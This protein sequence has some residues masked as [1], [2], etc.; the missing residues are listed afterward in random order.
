MYR[1]IESTPIQVT[2]SKTPPLWGGWEGLANINQ[3]L[4][5][6]PFGEI[7]TDHNPTNWRQDKIPEYA[8]NAKELDEENGMYYY[9]ARYYAPP[10]FISRDP[11]FEKYPSI[12]PYTYCANNPMKYVDPTGKEWET[13][14][15]NNLANKLIKNA[16]F[17]IK[18]YNSAIKRETKKMLKAQES[19]N[20]ELA[21]KYQNNIND[22]NE[23]NK[24][25]RE[26]IIGLQKMG[27]DKRVFH[28]NIS[29]NTSSSVNQRKPG[30][31]SIIDLN[32]Y[33]GNLEGTA[34]HE[35]GHVADWLFNR[36]YKQFDSKGRLGTEQS[37]FYE[38]EIRNNKSQ[39]SYESSIYGGLS[40]YFN[41]VKSVS[42]IDEKFVKSILGK[43]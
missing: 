38:S 30:D 4:L 42:D 16:K 35:M 37:D 21:T 14:N 32:V 27:K 2:T 7:I 12:S 15:D 23:K 26:G 9:S 20:D 5:Y 17:F 1:P 8:F 3:G 13:E 6:A 28:F 39:Y 22:Y 25:L 18:M 36:Y 10:T 31:E 19:G 41:G 29:N 40:S 34:W 24:Y 33:S 43:P 11:M